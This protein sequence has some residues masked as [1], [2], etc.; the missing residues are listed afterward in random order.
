MCNGLDPHRIS[1]PKSHE[2]HC[3]ENRATASPVST[4]GRYQ[5]FAN[6]CLALAVVA[7]IGLS[8]WVPQAALAQT[9]YWRQQGET[10]WDLRGFPTTI[11]ADTF[12]VLDY[13]PGHATLRVSGMVGGGLNTMV[14]R[15]EWE[16]PPVVVPGQIIQ[17]TAKA[18]AVSVS[19]GNPNFPRAFKYPTLQWQGAGS[20]VEYVEDTGIHEVK[21]GG[22]TRIGTNTTER[23]R[24]PSTGYTGPGEPFQFKMAVG[25]YNGPNAYVPYVWVNGVPPPVINAPAGTAQTAPGSREVA[26]VGPG[27]AASNAPP[28]TILR[29][30]TPA[31]NLRT[32]AGVQ[33][34]P[35]AITQVAFRVPTL[36]TKIM[37]YHYNG[38][39][40]AN[41]GTIGLRNMATGQ[42]YGPWRATG[43][44]QWY[45]MSPGAPW[46]LRTDGPPF[47][48]WYLQPNAVVPAGN[49]EVVDSDPGTW[50]T[51]SEVKGMGVAIVIGVPATTGVQPQT[52]VDAATPAAGAGKTEGAPFSI[53]GNW[54]VGGGRATI[55]QSGDRLVFTNEYGQRSNGRFLRSNIVVATD[56]DNGLE[57]AIGVNIN[58]AF[59]GPTDGRDRFNREVNEIRWKNG[60]RW[61][62]Q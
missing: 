35:T 2:I 53:A 12:E 49:Y 29:N 59:Y 36:V 48:Y 47:L 58:G 41:P 30:E 20:P 42:M 39:R 33:N 60:T 34:G 50:A 26:P 28:A 4:G 24:A 45:D 40:G 57:A 46:S 27:P 1:F 7:L 37:T 9:G 13:A 16:L 56:W 17:G 38:G 11:A 22:Q 5:R 43:S 31:L 6:G 21:S 32:D 19:Y 25:C 44:R 54:L 23:A 51:N 10:R 55:E 8:G 3:Q 61:I 52:Q 14:W 15:C 62:R 18:I